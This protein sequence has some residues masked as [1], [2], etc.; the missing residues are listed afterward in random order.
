MMTTNHEH[1]VA[2][3][4]ADRRFF[5][6]DVS[7]EHVRDPD[8]FGPLYRDLD[9]G[10]REQFLWLLQ[11]LKLGKWHPR[12]LLKTPEAMEQQRMSGD[13]IDQWSRASVEADEIVGDDGNETGLGKL[14]AFKTLRQAYV[15]YCKQQMM[16]PAGTDALA[17]ALKGIFGKKVRMPKL[18]GT[19]KRPWGYN[20]P[21]G[22]DWLVKLDERLGIKRKKDDSA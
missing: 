19:E 11:N 5:V 10:G 14:V 20:V 9:N 22:D 2:A 16:H 18:C 13:S 15:G 7:D 4:I 1:A 12:D 17:K 21:D 8:W 6:L 3:G